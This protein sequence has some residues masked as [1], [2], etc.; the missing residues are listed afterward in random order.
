MN[1]RGCPTAAHSLLQN[2]LIS[3]TSSWKH[4]VADSMPAI[5]Y[6]ANAH[7]TSEPIGVQPCYQ[8]EI[9]NSSFKKSLYSSVQQHS[10]LVVQ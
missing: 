10:G 3:I 9:L 1:C 5:W 2:T 8:A 7:Y 6:F 4:F